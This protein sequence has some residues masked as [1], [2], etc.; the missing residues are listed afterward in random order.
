MCQDNHGHCRAAMIGSEIERI[1]AGGLHGRTHAAASWVTATGFSASEMSALAAN[2]S[3]GV[4]SPPVTF[5]IASTKPRLGATLWDSS[6]EIV[7][8][9]TPS[10]RPISMV[11]SFFAAR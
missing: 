6:R 1:A 2:R 11:V 8:C 7:E 4:T 5:T 10:S 3:L 9:E